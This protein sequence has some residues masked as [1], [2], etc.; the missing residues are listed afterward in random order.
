MDTEVVNIDMTG[1]AD[2]SVSLEDP[3]TI[4]V[5][6]E[7]Q[8]LGEQDDGS[9]RITADVDAADLGDDG[10]SGDETEGLNLPEKFAN[11]EDPQAA[12]L[13][14]Y[15][16]L[17][18]SK[19][20]TDDKVEDKV[21][22]EEEVKPD[23][24]E[25]K[26]LDGEFSVKAYQDKWLEQSGQLS[27]AQWSE[28]EKNTGVPMETLRAYEASMVSQA[29]DSLASNDSEIY[30]LSGGEDKYNTMIDWANANLNGSQ[31]DS[32]N[33]QLDNPSFA[34][35]GVTLLKSMYEASEGKEASFLLGNLQN[36]SL[37]DT[38]IFQSDVEFYQAMEHPD[39]GKGGKYDRE[40]D[41]K[42]TAWMKAS[43]QI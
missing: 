32:I 21:E 31:I 14:A 42:A 33:T 12:L 10:N 40:F 38:D 4:T 37:K 3:N 6:P 43:G 35:N 22:V 5:T 18:K 24:S 30:K 11:A 8:E 17:E 41:R 36:N 15:L 1:G 7:E 23:V 25:A 9:I 2:P 34:A 20:T 27:D 16:E 39:Y 28:I 13:K 19:N 26:A 29:Q